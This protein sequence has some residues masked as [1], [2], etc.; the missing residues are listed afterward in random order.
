M[1]RLVPLV[2][3]LFGAS[4]GFDICFAHGASYPGGGYVPGPGGGAYGGPGNAPPPPSAPTGPGPSGPG[5]SSPSPGAPS[6]R[7][8]ATGGAARGP[9]GV[10]GADS[11]SV[12][13]AAWQLWWERNKWPYL[14]LKT[15][16]HSGIVTGSDEYFLALGGALLSK[17]TL[18]PSDAAIRTQVVPALLA[19]L[20]K[21][22]HNDVVTGVL[23]ALAKIGDESAGSRESEFERV[24]APFL[25]DANQEIAE[26]ASL[27][28]GILANDASML[29]LIHVAHDSHAGRKL[30]GD[31]EVPVRAR[32]F[33]TFGLGLI[34]YRSADEPL[35]QEIVENLMELLAAPDGAQ[36]DV[37]VAAMIALGIVPLEIDPGDDPANEPRDVASRQGQ[38]RALCRYFKSEAHAPLV[39]AHAPTAI[40]R[41]LAG[42]PASAKVSVARLLVASL[43]PHSKETDEV[44]QSCVLA[45]GQFGDAD[46]D[47]IDCEIRDALNRAASDGDAQSRR[48]A[49][50]AL[51]QV[52]GRPGAGEGNE[53]GM[54]GVR[55]TLLTR[56]TK[57]QSQTR[58]WAA[59]G[60]GVMERALVD[61][62]LAAHPPSPISKAA[63]REALKSSVVPSEV[64]AY[65]IASG[66]ARD[67]EATPILLEKLESVADQEARGYV[68]LALGLVGARDAIAPIR[69]LVRT[70][71]YK[72]A[73][74]N[75]AA[76]AL[77]L[78]GD[79]DVVP[80]LVAMLADA[81]GQATYAS[82]SSALGIIGDSRSI[83][84][85]V[86]MLGNAELTPTARAFAAVALGIVA[87]KEPLPWHAKISTNINYRA[88][89]S[90]LTGAGRGILD[91][92]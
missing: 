59:L 46:K 2:A 8:A 48:F 11:S 23:I 55:A 40:G 34:G 76:I 83:D 14:D 5:R 74:L 21:E 82:I 50:I 15:A 25:K 63:V 29:T 64:G 36:R 56:L 79:K 42:A 22:T 19:A 28:L 65:A 41:L 32:A 78:L 71:R 81:K 89:T 18:R 33:A 9:A 51:G 58:A 35:R 16:V 10:T 45:L 80:E 66:I 26:T 70:C 77:G 85:L 39:R 92:L 88:S 67:A 4:F 61:R 60:L 53:E 13:L 54:R 87:D 27:S 69:E 90:T 12:D 30:V 20:E 38:I 86:D 31:H 6:P 72:P 75:Q 73:L 17:D 24:I 43:S 68:A 52:G 37:K 57:G 62:K 91:I 49:L 44:K 7:G 47:P 3:L 84:P 1:H